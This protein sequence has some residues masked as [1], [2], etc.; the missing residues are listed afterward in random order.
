MFNPSLA[1][2]G[3]F[4]THIA[5]ICWHIWKARCTAVYEYRGEAMPDPRTVA[6]TAFAAA[7]DFLQANQKNQ[8][9][10]DEH[11]IIAIRVRDQRWIPPQADFVELNTDGSL[12]EEFK[13]VDP[14]VVKTNIM[15]EVPP[16][17]SNLAFVVLRLFCLLQSPEVGV[18]SI[19]DAALAPPILVTV[20]RE[21]ISGPQCCSN[22]PIINRSCGSDSA[23]KYGGLNVYVTGSTNAKIAILLISDVFGYGAPNLRSVVYD[24][25]W[26]LAFLLEDHGMDKGFEDAKSVID[27]LKGKGFSAIGAAGFCWGAKVVTEPA[28]FEFIQAAVLLH[29]SF[30][31]LDDIEGVKVPMAVVGAE[32]DNY[33]PP[34]LLKQFEEILNAKPEVDSYV[35]IFPKVA[36][37][38]SVRYNVDDE[39]AVKRADEAHND[40]L[41]WMVGV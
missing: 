29:P 26:P 28:K 8:N 38:W 22:P 4:L 21:V 16:C 27:A 9:Q 32:I 40:M 15:R 33:S 2:I 11:N 18:S 13:A 34:E 19:L 31:A 25:N 10:R 24:N 41:E 37:G 20:I 1:L 17:L 30:I 3:G 14:G 5:F 12:V 39:A 7:T 36:H 6:S 23:E 35:K